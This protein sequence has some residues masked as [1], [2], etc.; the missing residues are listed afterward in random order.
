MAIIIPGAFVA[1]VTYSIYEGN[2]KF[3]KEVVMPVTRKCFE[4]ETA[5]RLGIVAAKFNLVPRQKIPDSPILVS[6]AW[7]Q[8]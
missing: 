1:F 5:H 2:E 8:I 3:Y 7:S 6:V 4:A